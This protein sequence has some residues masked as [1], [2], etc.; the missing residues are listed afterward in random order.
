MK[1]TTAQMRVI[2]DDF[3]NCKVTMKKLNSLYGIDKSK[4]IYFKIHVECRKAPDY[5]YEGIITKEFYEKVKQRY[6]GNN[7]ICINEAF[8]HCNDLVLEFNEI[9]FSE[10]A[11][12]IEAYINQYGEST[13]H[14]Y[15]DDLF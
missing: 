9:V 6:V 12:T 14:E 15:F 13:D 11:K 4:Y 10:D 1:L 5:D 3:K 2:Y 7:K 8:G